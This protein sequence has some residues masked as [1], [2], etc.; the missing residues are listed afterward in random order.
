VPRIAD[1]CLEVIGQVALQAFGL[2]IQVVKELLRHLL[3]LLLSLIQ[4]MYSPSSRCFTNQDEAAQPAPQ[5]D[6]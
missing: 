5:K 6:I 2:A 3:Q 1:V 4:P